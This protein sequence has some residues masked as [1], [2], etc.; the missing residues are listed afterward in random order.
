MGRGTRSMSS[1]SLGPSG[2][3]SGVHRGISSF[4]HV[5][6]AAWT[7]VPT[8]VTAQESGSCLLNTTSLLQLPRELGEE[9][10]A[11]EGEPVPE[12]C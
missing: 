10:G 7:S 3:R 12:N 6:P 8:H 1:L 5:I 11:W 4:P 9:P 2:G